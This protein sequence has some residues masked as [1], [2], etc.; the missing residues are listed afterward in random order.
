MNC[1]HQT[2]VIAEVYLVVKDGRK[3][4]GR[5]QYCVKCE[6]PIGDVK[7]ESGCP[8]DFN[9]TTWALMIEHHHWAPYYVVRNDNGILVPEG[10]MSAT[11]VEQPLIPNPDESD[12]TIEEVPF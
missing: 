2:K 7:R 3:L 12:E 4:I 9:G 1:E 11:P 6:H 8:K 5:V 10:Y